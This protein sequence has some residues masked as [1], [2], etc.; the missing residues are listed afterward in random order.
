[1][2]YIARVEVEETFQNLVHEILVVLFNQ[3]LRRV[4]H[5][6]EV[7]VH[8]LCYEVYILELLSIC[9]RH[10]QTHQFQ[11]IG[12]F[13]EAKQLNFSNHPSRVLKRFESSSHLLDSYF[14]L[15]FNIQ[16]SS[17]DAVHSSTNTLD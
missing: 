5:L 6:K 7:C 2:H 8:Q 14:L 17:Y 16:H 3:F 4:Y 9:W 13:A 11:D 12:V 15:S 1:M 10:R